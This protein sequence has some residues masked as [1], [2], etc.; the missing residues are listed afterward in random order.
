M[1]GDLPAFGGMGAKILRIGRM[2]MDMI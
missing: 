1:S 2:K